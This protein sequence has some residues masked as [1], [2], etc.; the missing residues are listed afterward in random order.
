MT[1]VLD[2]SAVLAFLRDE[3]GANTVDGLFLDARNSCHIHA[4][5]LC[6]VFCSM[7]PRRGTRHASLTE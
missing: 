7:T 1:V 4:L 3:Q 5:N 2:S 6:E